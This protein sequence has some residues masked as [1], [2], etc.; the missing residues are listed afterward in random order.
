MVD[1]ISEVQEELRKDDYN[2]WLRRYGPYL[3]G[4]VVAVLAITAWLEW[5]E[6]REAASAREVSLAYTTAS[7][8]AETDP[9]AAQAAF[10]EL[11]D[12][13]PE[14]YAGLAL[15]RAAALAVEAGEADTAV[16]DLDR[17]GATFALPRHAHLARLKAAYILAA[18]GRDAEAEARLASLA[19]KGAPYE[20]LA[21]ELGA[22]AALSQGDTA[23]AREGFNYLATIP[24]VTPGVAARSEQTLSLLRAGETVEMPADPT[25]ALPAP[26]PGA[27]LDAE[28]NPNDDPNEDPGDE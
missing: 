20:F 26:A 7:E 16:R 21:R 23:R 6:A 11:A 13:A 28:P 1:F 4:L 3:V 15:M 5:S 10:R 19:E 2:R 24:G 18:E 12:R 14:G 22:Y 8:L 17:A 25:S 27:S 9:A